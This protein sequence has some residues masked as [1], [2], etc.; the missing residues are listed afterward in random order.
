MAADWNGFDG[1]PSIAL[2]TA[3]P[4]SQAKTETT[5][6][7]PIKLM[8]ETRSMCVWEA[9]SLK[10]GGQPPLTEA[11]SWRRMQSTPTPSSPWNTHTSTSNGRTDE[12]KTIL[13]EHGGKCLSG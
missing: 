4:A 3:A 7:R 1:S 6:F 9:V 8:D 12:A 5:R 11:V 10:C 2:T 13:R